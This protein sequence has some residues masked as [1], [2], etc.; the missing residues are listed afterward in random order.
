MNPPSPELA[1]FLLDAGLA[2][3]GEDGEWTPLTGGVSSDIWSVELAR[4][5]VCVKRA[6]EQLRVS[7]EWVVPTDRNEVEWNFL[8]VVAAIIPGQVPAP[9]AHDPSHGLFAMCWL[10]PRNYQLWKSKL[11]AGDV[12]NRDAIEVGRLMGRIHSATA[13]DPN[14][15]RQ[16]RTDGNFHALRIEPYLLKIAQRHADL[17]ATIS[18]IAAEVTNTRIALV[19]G[20]VSP[21]NILLG[22]RGPV[23]LDAECAWFGDPAFDLAFCLNHLVLK[24]HLAPASAERLAQAFDALATTYLANVDWESPQALEQRTATLLPALA[25]ARIDG[26]SPVEYLDQAARANVRELARA[27]ISAAPRELKT[28]RSCLFA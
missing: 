7:D 3:P 2:D 28:V 16:F 15:E 21:K 26:K 9:L 14:V 8:K 11:L 10:P 23:L 13:F 22:P 4:G 20:D 18:A 6:L 19:H 5:P 17:A 25:L 27:T 1:A 12:Q 24:A